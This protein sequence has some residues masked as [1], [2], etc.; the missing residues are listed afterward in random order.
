[1]M[2]ADEIFQAIRSLPGDE[3]RELL[4]RVAHELGEAPPESASQGRQP[5]P[6][7][8]RAAVGMDE[9]KIWIAEDFD[10]PLP[11]ELQ[12]AFEGEGDEP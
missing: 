7:D 5:T 11:E 9:G 8:R 12:R 10:G 6:A 3:R 4:A 1:M 2:T